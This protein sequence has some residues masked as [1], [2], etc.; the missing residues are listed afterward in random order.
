MPKYP[1]SNGVD[2]DYWRRKDGTMLLVGDGHPKESEH[3]DPD[4][5][6]RDVDR[7]FEEMI[8]ERLRLRLPEFARQAR[9]VKGYASLYDVTP[10]WHPVLGRV[11]GVEGCVLCIGFSGHGFKLGPAIGGLIAEEILDGK[12][13]SLDI[14]PLRL[15]RFAEKKLL[16]GAYAGNQA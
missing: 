7:S 11:A 12:A 13:H 3:A 4:K 2:R 10:D 6:K 15:S 9:I 5:F 1:V 14:S 16:Q 8:M